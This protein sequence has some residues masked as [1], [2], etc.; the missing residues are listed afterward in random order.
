MNNQWQDFQKEYT[1]ADIN[2]AVNERLFKDAFTPP[3]Q[4]EISQDL[5]EY[6]A[7][8]EI[9]LFGAHFYYAFSPVQTINHWQNFK[10]LNVPKNYVKALERLEKIQADVPE[11]P[12]KGRI[13]RKPKDRVKGRNGPAKST[14]MPKPKAKPQRTVPQWEGGVEEEPEPE[15]EPPKKPMIVIP[16]DVPVAAIP[17]ALQRRMAAAEKQSELEVFSFFK[18]AF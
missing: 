15:P 12:I 11:S 5:H 10:I 4:I 8:Q 6:V 13:S 3:Y 17:P 14:S 2:R 1:T 9:P 16:T 18:E 7:F